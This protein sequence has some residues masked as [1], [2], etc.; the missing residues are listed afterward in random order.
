MSAI[1][2]CDKIVTIVCFLTVVPKKICMIE[3]LTM[4]AAS[5]YPLQI[6]LLVASVICQPAFLCASDSS[7]TTTNAPL[8]AQNAEDQFLLGRSYYRGEGVNQ[9][10]EQ[11]GFWYRKAAEQGNLKAMNNIGIM[12]LEG[13]GVKKDEAEGYRWIRMAAEKGDPHAT[14]LCGKLLCEGRGV[15]KN[16]NE[17]IDWL[18]KSAA[19][20][21]S[22]ALA[23]LGQDTLFGDHSL[24]KNPAAAFPLIQK[25]AEMG[26][27]WACGAMGHFYFTGQYVPQDRQKALD[28]LKKGAD[29]G[30]LN[31][32]GE[33]GDVLLQ[34]GDPYKAY[35]YLSVG[36]DGPYPR[37]TMALSECIRGLSEDQLRQASH[38]AETLQRKLAAK[39]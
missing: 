9:S 2:D 37:I 19:L 17:G 29:L 21:N 12:F 30:D 11:A 22:T 16:T 15:K 24:K 6:C 25:A 33:Y 32:I 28:W 13:Q 4:K 1:S 31:A 10:Y 8:S 38:E 7:N 18:K 23:L 3:S 36:K 20:G 39:H 14:Y 35:I 26:N 34:S 5:L 27:P